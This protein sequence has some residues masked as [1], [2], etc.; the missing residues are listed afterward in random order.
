MSTLHGSQ[1]LSARRA[2][3]TK[4]KG[5]KGLQLLVLEYLLSQFAFFHWDSE[6]C[7]L[8]GIFLYW[9]L[10]DDNAYRSTVDYIVPGEME[11]MSAVI[12][13]IHH[14]NQYLSRIRHYNKCLSYIHH[15]TMQLSFS[16]NGNRRFKPDF[17]HSSHFLP[18]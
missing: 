12:S 16:K 8:V 4:S 1:G 6:I 17:H 18:V 9:D 7:V 3:R 11:L 15:C 14:C 2:R 5:P 10:Y 13:Q